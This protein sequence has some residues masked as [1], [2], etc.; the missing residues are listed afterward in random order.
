MTEIERNFVVLKAR[1]QWPAK[2]AARAHLV[3]AK[4]VTQISQENSISIEKMMEN[5]NAAQLLVAALIVAAIVNISSGFQ[6]HR[7]S[8]EGHH[9]NAKEHDFRQPSQRGKLFEF[10]IYCLTKLYH[11][12]ILRQ[13]S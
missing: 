9:H 10:Y 3:N 1:P 7:E 13:I 6:H 5:L 12:K 8:E 11:Q 4:P 2:S